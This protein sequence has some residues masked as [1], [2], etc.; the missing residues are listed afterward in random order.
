M[1]IV[2]N[3]ALYQIAW[4]LC[5]FLENMG[6][7]IAFSLLFLHLYLSPTKRADLRLMGLLLL[8]GLIMDGILFFAGF[9]KFNAPSLPIPFWLAVIWLFLATLPHHSLNW[10]KKRP[11]LSAIFGAVGGPLAYWAGVRIG[12]AQFGWE[13]PLSFTVLAGLWAILW[14]LVMWFADHEIPRERS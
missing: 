8:A 10:L 13:L 4:F 14:P 11:L 6:G 5:V 9:L 12:A 2:A 3:F 7:L 1:N